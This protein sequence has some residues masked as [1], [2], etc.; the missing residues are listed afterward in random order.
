MFKFLTAPV[1]A[2]SIALSGFTPTPARADDAEVARLIAGFAALAFIGAVINDQ[3]N[4][5]NSKA[6]VHHKPKVYHKPKVTV[7]KNYVHKRHVNPH[8]K[9]IAK[10]RRNV[11][12]ASCFEIVP[13]KQGNRRGFGHYCLHKKYK[14]ASSLPHFCKSKVRSRGKD[15]TIYTAN[16]LRNQGYKMSGI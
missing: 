2:A 7:H 13:T 12:P 5:S 9:R 3:N 11:V 1:L 16:C 6:T 4:K 14:Y 15:R 8:H 10:P